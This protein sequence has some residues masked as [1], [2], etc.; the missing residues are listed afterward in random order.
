MQH[1]NE[2]QSVE[3]SA[4]HASEPRAL[5]VS[6]AMS[7]ARGALEGIVVRMIGEVSEVSCKPGYKA[8]YFTVKDKSAALP[9]MM[10]NNRYEV[11]GVRLRVGQMAELTGRFTLYAPKGRMNF[12]VFSLALAGEGV[13]RQQVADLARK[14]EAEGLMRAARKRALPVLPMCVGLVT[15]PRGAA[16]HDVL[17]TLRRRFPLARVA[18]AG[19]PVEGHEAPARV[20]EGMRRVCAAG[21]EVVLVV[22]GGGSFE[23]LMPFNDEALARAIATCS[24]PVVTGI[25]HEPDTSIADMVADVRASTPTAAAETAAPARESLQNLF[26][27]QAKSLAACVIRCL[28]REEAALMRFSERPAFRD[29]T[30]L[31]AREAQ[32]LDMAADRLARALPGNLERDRVRLGATADRLRLMMPRA[33]DREAARLETVR[34]RMEACGRAVV[35]RFQNEVGLAAARLHDLSPLAIVARGYAVARTEQGT[36][37]KSIEQA[38]VGSR[39]GVTVSNGELTCRVEGACRIDTSIESWEE[40]TA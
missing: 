34:G 22:R 14:L 1:E 7:R 6:A 5:S 36:V 2:N 23:D 13:L 40:E 8:A 24:V 27:T 35:S 38:P 21:A 29:S 39:V 3:T 12:E 33:V 28:D 4:S 9:C 20:I 37:V 15:S 19:V 11:S 18:V 31:C 25:G 16:V 32:T 30:W 10:W 26:E 17:R